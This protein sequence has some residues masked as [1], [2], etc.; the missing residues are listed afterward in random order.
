MAEQHKKDDVVKVGESLNKLP[1][2]DPQAL[3]KS[4]AE[5]DANKE[6]NKQF[7]NNPVQELGQHPTR[8]AVEKG[9]D[10]SPEAK[11]RLAD[12]KRAEE[13]TANSNAAVGVGVKAE[14]AE[15]M[16]KAQEYLKEYGG[17]EGNIPVHHDYWVVMNRLRAMRAPKF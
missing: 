3:G 17:L 8:N 5:Q 13:L 9:D 14:E 11:Q 4:P 6:V 1:G 7:P 16:K 10:I 12:L 15:L 2:A